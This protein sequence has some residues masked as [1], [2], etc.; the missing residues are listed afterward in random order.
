MKQDELK[1]M[2]AEAAVEF[3]EDHMIVGLGTGSTVMH[4]VTALAKRVKAENLTI[5]GVSTS[6]RTEIQA[7]DLGITMKSIDDVDHVDL[8]IDG[9]DEVDKSFN[10][11][12]GGGAAHAFE[13]IVATSSTRNLWI[14]DESKLVDRIGRFP[15]PIEVIPYGSKKVFARLASENLNPQF[16][17]DDQGNDV[18]TDS[19]NFIIDLHLGVVEHPHLLANWLSEQVGV[20]E[21]GLFLDTVDTVIV[22]TQD[23]PKILHA[24]K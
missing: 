2:A 17:K 3:V 8:T 6:R 11:I 21:H 5:V 1:K 24:H 12:K 15:L 18:I 7:E 9:A 4:M 23:G 16:R 14:V 20:L 19:G 10:G 22:G 13:K